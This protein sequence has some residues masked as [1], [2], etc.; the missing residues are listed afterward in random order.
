MKESDD[1]YV[2]SWGLNPKLSIYTSESRLF[3]VDYLDMVD[4]FKPEFGDELVFRLG[5]VFH[6]EK[7]GVYE[8][9]EQIPMAHRHIWDQ[10]YEFMT[11]ADFQCTNNERPDTWEEYLEYVYLN[12][13]DVV[14]RV[15][16]SESF[17]IIQKKES[18]KKQF[19][20]FPRHGRFVKLASA[21][22][23]RYL[24]FENVPPSF[25][26]V[27]FIRRRKFLCGV[28]GDIPVEF[29]FKKVWIGRNAHDILSTEI[30]PVLEMTLTAKPLLSHTDRVFVLLSCLEKWMDLFGRDQKPFVVSNPDLQVLSEAIQEHVQC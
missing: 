19:F 29:E 1:N 5:L 7:E 2:A 15:Q 14:T 22:E 20:F 26:Q 30:E 27:R 6:K 12:P 13:Q 4:E 3:G 23:S 28:P 21:R 11:H 8:W 24:Q 16:N 18:E 10:C 9:I 25:H 17:D